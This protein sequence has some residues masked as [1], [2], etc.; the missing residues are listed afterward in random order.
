MLVRLNQNKSA[1]SVARTLLR[2]GEV[3]AVPTETAY[4]LLA[5]AR[6][7]KAINKIF[8]FKERHSTKTLPLI[9]AS[10]V[11]AKK[12]AIFSNLALKLAKE[13]WPG[14]LTMVLPCRVKF[15]KGIIEKDNTIALRVPDSKWL[16]SLLKEMD[17]PLTSTSANASGAPT[18]Y[19]S[20]EVIKQLGPR[21]LKYIVIKNIQPKPTSTIVA[22]QG[23]RIRILRDG[24][25]SRAKI[26]MVMKN[27]IKESN[28]K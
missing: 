21:G 6:N 17:V 5:D 24:A 28:G 25:I 11:Q 22:T 2:E 16:C 10:L 12:Y 1:L 8:K 20:D 4:G 23:D 9:V 27:F 13:F 14:P 26:K 7:S 19:S 15:P 3:L 18:L